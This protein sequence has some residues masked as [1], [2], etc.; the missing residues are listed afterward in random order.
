MLETKRDSTIPD[1]A[2]RIGI[3]CSG[4][5]GPETVDAIMMVLHGDSPMA[6]RRKIL[7]ARPKKPK[8]KREKKTQKRKRRGPYK[9][10]INRL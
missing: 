10:N 3:N 1:L 6:A 7:K 8:K 2:S 4:L 5:T 9:K